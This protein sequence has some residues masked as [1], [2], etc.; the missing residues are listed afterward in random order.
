MSPWELQLPTG[1]GG[2]PDTELPSQLEGCNGYQDARHLYFFTESGD[3]ALVMKVPG[4]PAS[5]GCV[6]TSNSE[7]C[8]TELREIN[9]PNWD[10]NASINRLSVSLAVPVPDKSRYGTVIG[11][12]HIDNSISSKPVCELYY[13]S[14]GDLNMGVEQ[15]RGGRDEK[16]MYIGNVPVDTPFSYSI[17]YESNIVWMRL[18]V[19]S[20]LGIITRAVIRPLYISSQSPLNTK[21]IVRLAAEHSLVNVL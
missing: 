2:N 3:G 13:S 11:Q 5:S 20:R 12:I 8:R 14:S 1:T 10:P 18:R 6:T 19:I 7:H 21:A 16:I 4:S 15:T 9:P 17:A